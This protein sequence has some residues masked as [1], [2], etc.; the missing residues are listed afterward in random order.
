MKNLRQLAGLFLDCL[1]RSNIPGF[2]PSDSVHIVPP[3]F[4]PQI[5][6]GDTGEL[7]QTSFSNLGS[8]G[9]KNLFKCCFAIAFHLLATELSSMLPTLL[10]HF[11]NCYTVFFLLNCDHVIL[12][13]NFVGSL[14]GVFP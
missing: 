2:A 1:V 8:G 4:L 10:E 6:G 5:E 9:K 14:Y 12:D 13:G 7:V 11:R 3:W